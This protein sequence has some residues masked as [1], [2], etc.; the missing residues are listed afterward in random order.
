MKAINTKC[1]HCGCRMTVS[2][3]A[4]AP[5]QLGSKRSTFYCGHCNRP[6]MLNRRSRLA[7]A[8]AVVSIMVGSVVLALQ[9]DRTSAAP[10]V[11]LIVGALGGMVVG[12][13]ISSRMPALVKDGPGA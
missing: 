5:L 2:I 8:L 7:G 11:V 3:A 10:V 9:L 12:A 1:A 6:S 4:L 13:W